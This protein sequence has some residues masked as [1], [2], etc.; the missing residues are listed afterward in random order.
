[1]LARLTRVATIALLPLCVTAAGANTRDEIIVTGTRLHDTPAHMTNSVSIID[2][3]EIEARGESNFIDLLRGLPGM[4]VTSPGGSGGTT[5]VTM[6]GGEANYTVVLIDGVKVNDPTDT[7]GGSA[8]SGCESRRAGP[9]SSNC[10][11]MAAVSCS[12]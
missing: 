8:G 1:M 11:T 12:I 4:H 9:R 6:R 10:S 2:A 7:R 5:S 3:E